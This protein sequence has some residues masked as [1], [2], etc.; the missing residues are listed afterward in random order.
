MVEPIPQGQS[1]KKQKKECDKKSSMSYLHKFTTS[2]TPF[3]LE[4]ESQKNAIILMVIG[5]C[6]MRFY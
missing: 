1:I 2:I 5:I 6:T 3:F 4:N